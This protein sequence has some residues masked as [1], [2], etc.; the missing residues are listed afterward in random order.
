MRRAALSALFLAL[1]ALMRLRLLAEL[2]TAVAVLAAAG[3]TAG[4]TP[5][6]AAAAASEYALLTAAAAGWEDAL[7]G[8][9][10]RRPRALPLLLLLRSVR[11]GVT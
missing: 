10:A 11:A 3:L 4:A 9:L 2:A 1:R 5:A 6:W 7:A 8:V